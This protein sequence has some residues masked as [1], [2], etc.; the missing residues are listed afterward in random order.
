MSCQPTTKTKIIKITSLEFDIKGGESTGGIHGIDFFFVVSSWKLG[1]YEG[2]VKAKLSGL[3]EL[4]K[5]L[6]LDSDIEP[7]DEDEEMKDSQKEVE[8][9]GT[10][11]VTLE[12]LIS[13]LKRKYFYA[14]GSARFMFD[15]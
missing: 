14:G 9:E 15:Y 8:E 12:W 6:C 13:L 7:D 3:D 4:Q 10:M 2:A 5:I 1:D 11:E